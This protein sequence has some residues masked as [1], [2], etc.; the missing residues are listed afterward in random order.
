MRGQPQNQNNHNQVH[1]SSKGKGLRVEK[2][3]PISKEILK[4]LKKIKNCN[5]LLNWRLKI[6]DTT[7]QKLDEEV[8]E[9]KF[10]LIMDNDRNQEME[11]VENIVEDPIEVKYEDKSTTHNP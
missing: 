1:V 2:K 7:Y 6:K 10:E 4:W 9:K 3:Q 8:K 11:I 5:K